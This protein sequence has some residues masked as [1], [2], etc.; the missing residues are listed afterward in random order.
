MLGPLN[1]RQQYIR[2]NGQF[3]AFLFNKSGIP[4]GS[5]LRPLIFLIYVHDLS[6]ATVNPSF[7]VD[8]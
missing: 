2:C 7:A 1:N 8:K 3:L 6:I 4:R 5:I